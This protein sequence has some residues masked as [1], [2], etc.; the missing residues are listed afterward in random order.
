M[1][2]SFDFLNMKKSFKIKRR[3]NVDY[4]RKS[5]KLD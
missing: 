1:L 4:D 2:S 5:L 3:F